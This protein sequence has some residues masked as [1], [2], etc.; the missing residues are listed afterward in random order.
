[1]VLAV[2]LRQHLKGNVA[3]KRAAGCHHLDHSCSRAGRDGGRDLGARN[4]RE[5]GCCPIKGDA[6]GAGEIASQNFDSLSHHA[7]DGQCRNKRAQADRKG[8]D[9]AAAVLAGGASPAQSGCAIEVPIGV[10][11]Q[12]SGGLVSFS[13]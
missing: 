8:E 2:I 7:G 10:L 5:D 9:G 13:S 1:M 6:G 11:D 4:H 3:R 12:G